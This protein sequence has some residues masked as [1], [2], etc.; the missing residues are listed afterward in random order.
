MRKPIHKVEKYENLK[1]MLSK[2]GEKFGNSPAY[3]FKTDIPG[4]FREITH[5]EFR[6]EINNLGTALIDMELKDKRIAV[7]SENRYEWG[8]AYLAIATGTGVV[9]PLDKALPDNEIES[10]IIRSEVEAIFYSNKYD[11]IMQKIRNQKNTKVKYFISMDLEKEK[12]GIY[13][14]S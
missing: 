7:I 13:S 14:Q 10:L 4:K 9:V 3:R 5:K 2:T 1:E 11:S 12:D 6:N 8:V